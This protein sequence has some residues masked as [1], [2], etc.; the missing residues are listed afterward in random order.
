MNQKCPRSRKVEKDIKNTPG[1][2]C[3]PLGTNKYYGVKYSRR[4]ATER[5]FRKMELLDFEG[6][7]ATIDI[8]DDDNYDNTDVFCEE[9]DEEDYD[10]FS[11]CDENSF[12]HRVQQGLLF[13]S[14]ENSVCGR[15]RCPKTW[16]IFINPFE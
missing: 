7:F 9:D 5:S 16:Y 13:P 8:D 11:G 15:Q 3:T 12:A 4:W 10:L 6:N 14:S 2:I 1:T